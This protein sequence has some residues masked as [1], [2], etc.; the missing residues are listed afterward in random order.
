MRDHEGSVPVDGD[1]GPCQRTG[2]DGRV[3]EARV[4]IV[5]E[6][7]GAEVEEVEDQ[8]ELS[9]DEMGADKEHDE[10]EV[11]EVVEDKVAADARRGMDDVRVGGEQVTNVAGLENE[12]D[13]PDPVR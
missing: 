2:H 4:S 8:N 1:K 3:D 11:E 12:E 7:E 6:V 10:G 5:A 13:N 9:P